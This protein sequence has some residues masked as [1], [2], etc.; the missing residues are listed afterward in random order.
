MAKCKSCTN[1]ITV[2]NRSL[3]KGIC[4]YCFRTTNARSVYRLSESRFDGKPLRDHPPVPTQELYEKH[5]V[6]LR[7]GPHR[8]YEAE[9]TEEEIKLL[10]QLREAKVKRIHFPLPYPE[11]S[12]NPPMK[13]SEPEIVE[14]EL[15]DEELKIL[16]D[17]RAVKRFN[18]R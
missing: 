2:K 17:M 18:G 8:G 14:V 16:A 6:A 13:R 12:L 3:I 11:A 9:L 15:S 10:H 7:E 4:S 5:M 1:P